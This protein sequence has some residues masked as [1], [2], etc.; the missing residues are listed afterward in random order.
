M[1]RCVN[2]WNYKRD[3]LT[4]AVTPEKCQLHLGVKTFV[5]KYIGSDVFF[6][7]RICRNV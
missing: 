5:H 7:K 2:V 3:H 6:S 4:K 1:S